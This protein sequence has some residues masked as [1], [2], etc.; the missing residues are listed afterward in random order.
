MQLKDMKILKRA[1]G[2]CKNQY[3]KHQRNRARDLFIVKM[4]ARVLSLKMLAAPHL[5]SIF[6]I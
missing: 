2:S 4:R 3:S 6:S 5:F 1:L